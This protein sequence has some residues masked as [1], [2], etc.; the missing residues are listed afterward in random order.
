MNWKSVPFEGSDRYYTERGTALK[1]LVPLS[2]HECVSTDRGQWRYGKRLSVP[3][4]DNVLV[5]SARRLVTTK[6]PIREAKEL[7]LLWGN[8][9]VSVELDNNGYMTP[10]G[11]WGGAFWDFFELIRS[12]RNA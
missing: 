9:V 8:K 2:A 4:G 7:D 5:L 11:K 6:A 10:S 12:T 1:V 3:M